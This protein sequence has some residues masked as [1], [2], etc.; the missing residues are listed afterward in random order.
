M[1]QT[2]KI[3]S[4]QKLVSQGPLVDK[5]KG[6]FNSATINLAPE[7]VFKFCQNED[8]LK[9]VLTNLPMNI[10]NFLDLELQSA[11]Q[12]APG[13]YKIVWQNK[14]H[15]KF[16]G[17]IHFFLK[18]APVKRGTLVNL[19]AGFDKIDLSDDEPSTLINMFL[20]RMKSLIETGEIATTLGQP[21]GKEEISSSKNKTL[22]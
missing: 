11:Q 8:N 5:E 19:Q 14:P 9:H 18:K 3:E 21:T 6:Y 15:S 13:S 12:A 16:S 4:E 22:H 7:K 17:N 20:K 1:N 2:E 10:E